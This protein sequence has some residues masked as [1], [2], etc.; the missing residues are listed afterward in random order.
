LDIKVKGGVS[1]NIYFRK[2][3]E[4]GIIMKSVIVRK[5]ENKA[6]F[7]KDMDIVL[8]PIEH[9]V[10]QYN[11]LISDYEC[12][13]YPDKRIQ[14]NQKYAWISGKTLLKIFKKHKIQF[15]W[16]AFSAFPKD[17]SLDTVLQR[18]LPYSEDYVGHWRNPVGIQHPLAEIEIVSC[19]GCLTLF[20]AKDE[21]LVDAFVSRFPLA[22]PLEEYNNLSKE[23]KIEHFG[24]KNCT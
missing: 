21:K 5:T 9:A 15:I 13:Q 20:I 24:Y 12:N 6:L 7:F 11:W 23:E 1:K 17:I 18:W 19:D 22:M 4:R 10:K 8:S 16:S 3:R 2:K 14:W